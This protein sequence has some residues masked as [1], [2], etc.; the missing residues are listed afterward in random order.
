MKK[1]R[2]YV[3]IVVA[4]V[5]TLSLGGVALAA[6]VFPSSESGGPESGAVVDLPAA[7]RSEEA[8]QSDSTAVPPDENPS[9]SS[10]Q[11]STT[12]ALS[13]TFS[14]YQVTGAAMTPRDSSTQY[15]YQSNGC[16][17]VTAG[18]TLVLNTDLHIPTGSMIKYLRLIYIDTSSTGEIPAYLTS[19]IPGQ[20]VEDL[21]ST[22]STT[23]F[24][25]GYGYAV[26]TEKSII[27]DN[28]TYAYS[29][30][31]KPS[32]SGTSLQICGVRVAYYAPISPTIYLPAI[33]R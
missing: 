2:G 16:V 6:G 18:N 15:T 25:G 22:S 1:S 23:L 27:V 33:Q 21:I 9:T 5:L 12:Y 10:P 24:A 29:L 4:F 13:S 8:A 19:F 32:I 30:L 28:Q 7:Y 31:V 20:Q 14:Y 11:S 26:S 17:S 3:A